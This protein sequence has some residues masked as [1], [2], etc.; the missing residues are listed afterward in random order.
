MHQRCLRF[1]GSVQK[2]LSDNANLP[3]TGLVTCCVTARSC[4]GAVAEQYIAAQRFR[5]ELPRIE[6]MVCIKYK[7]GKPEGRGH[8]RHRHMMN[9]CLTRRLILGALMV[10]LGAM[11][12][13]GRTR[14]VVL[15]YDERPTLPGLRVREVVRIVV[16]GTGRT[17]FNELYLFSGF[18]RL[19][20]IPPPVL[21]LI[22]CGLAPTDGC[23]RHA[24][25][26]R[27]VYI[28]GSGDK[29]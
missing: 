8:Q 23:R 21:R 15:L 3:G 25:Q 7:Q 11:P 18:L 2:H 17:G 29:S 24:Q 26:R 20:P 28:M 6:P 10:W 4:W 22:N 12:A 14:Q 5:N 19:D 1:R 13:H 27:S 9:R 16:L